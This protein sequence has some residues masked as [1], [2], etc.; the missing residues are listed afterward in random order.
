MKLL[1]WIVIVILVVIAFKAYN[2]QKTHGGT[3]MQN[4]GKAT[5]EL[6]VK[7]EKIAKEKGK[8]FKQGFDSTENVQ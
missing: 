2:R 3:F 8:E 5:K 1:K 6:F 4:A 7:G